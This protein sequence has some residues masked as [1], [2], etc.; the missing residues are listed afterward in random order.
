MKKH[1][2]MN[3]YLFFTFF[4]MLIWE[5]RWKIQRDFITYGLLS[6]FFVLLF[7]FCEVFE[8][9]IYKILTNFDIFCYLISHYLHICYISFC[10][11]CSYF[12]LSLSWQYCKHAHVTTTTTTNIN[13]EEKEEKETKKNH[14]LNDA[15]QNSR[16]ILPDH[17]K[18]YEQL[19][20]E[21][22]MQ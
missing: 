8:E 20:K 22:Y 13:E 11:Q 15:V 6:L 17:Y 1:Q 2:N 7:L 4:K 16:I 9:F 5:K 19:K 10:L 18:I 14:F 3:K 21:Q 12:T